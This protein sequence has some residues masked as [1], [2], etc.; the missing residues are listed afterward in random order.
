MLKCDQV[1]ARADA[2]VDGESLSFRERWAL[3]LHLLVCHHCRRYLRQLRM[4]VTSLRR[5]E[6]TV[7]PA[8]VEQ[9][10]HRIDREQNS[11]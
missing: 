1:V 6:E 7:D 10:L 9:V 8:T 4:L 11:H 5:N 2:L 3:R